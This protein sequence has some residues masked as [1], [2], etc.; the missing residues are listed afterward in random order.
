MS[1]QINQQL[2]SKHRI[3]QTHAQFCN[4]LDAEIVNTL[5]H[6]FESNTISKYI[7]DER[8]VQGINTSNI[9]ISSNVTI[10]G[11]HKSSLYLNIKKNDL[12][13]IHL[14]IHLC[15]TNLNPEKQGIVHMFKNVFNNL[16]R[17]ATMTKSKLRRL[18]PRMYALITVHQPIN[19]PN[20]LEFTIENEYLTTNVP[21]ANK[22]DTELQKEMRVVLNVL[23]RLFDENNT[24]YYIGDKKN[25]INIHNKTNAIL[26]N[27]NKYTNYATRKNRGVL[28]GP[29][30]SNQPSFLINQTVFKKNRKT[31]KVHSKHKN[32]KL[33]NSHTNL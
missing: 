3:I 11:T 23:N 2:Q 6:L 20:S 18:K 4:F 30:S 14:S 1:Q 10:E 15:I 33:N 7:Q 28:L 5:V 21:N 26:E 19:K 29:K 25:I 12:D 13:Y 31:R 24:E 32:T 27:I 17:D 8:I 22:N 9:E 16:T